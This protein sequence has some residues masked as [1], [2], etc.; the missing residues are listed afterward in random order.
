M[1]APE[2]HKA[3]EAVLAL[4][5]EGRWSHAEMAGRVGVSV[6]TIERWTAAPDFKQRIAAMR[7]NLAESLSGVVY[8]DKASRIVG[9]SQMAESAR[10]EYERRP[11]LLERRPTYRDEDTGEML[12]MEQEA[13][14]RDAHAAFRDALNDIAKELG[15]RS[16]SVKLSGTMQHSL[17]P[18]GALAAVADELHDTLLPFPEARAA[19]AAR[20]LASGE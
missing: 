15:E 12:Y 1:P 16:T 19:A 20:L 18:Q 13:F 7:A 14:N 4:A 5:F 17:V 11:L 3:Q 6:R 9:L 10:R 8:A 2:R